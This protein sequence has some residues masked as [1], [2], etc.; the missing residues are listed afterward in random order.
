MTRALL[1]LAATFLAAPVLA[2]QAD[3]H[4]G[5]STPA[6]QEPAA[7]TCTPEHAA[8]GH[9][10]LPE[11]PAT[12]PPSPPSP[13]ASTCTP[14]HAAM[15]H[16]S[17]PAGPQAD[18][19]AGHHMGQPQAAD[20]PLAPPPPEAL[21]GPAHA[22]DSVWGPAM[23]RSRNILRE[24]HGGMPAAKFLVDRAESSFRDGRD[25]YL[26]DVQASYGGDIDKLW[27]KSEVEGFWGRNPEHAEVQALWSHAIGPWFDLQ[28]GIRFDPQPGPNRTHL[29]LGVQ[30]LA[31]YWWEVEGTMFLSNKGELTARAEAEYDLRITQK[32]I[33]QPRFEALLSAQDIEELGIGSGLGEASLGL[34]LRYQVSP[35]VAPYL[36]V[37]YEHAFGDTRDFRH[38]EGEKADSLNLLAG[39]RFW[40]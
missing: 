3:P 1:L 12:P 22:A 33:L 8:M 25:G 24:E 17:M 11:T 6:A 27:F 2:Q 7:A 32:L 4:A 31:P 18:P 39:L 35:L 20:V 19:H 15:G 34:R 13:P 23:E 9:C 5:H 29:A 38:E 16:C 37:E 40:F 36:G 28:T 26:L 10:K 14:E 30:G 21:S